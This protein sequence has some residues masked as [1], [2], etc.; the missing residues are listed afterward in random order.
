MMGLFDNQDNDWDALEEQIN[1]IIDIVEKLRSEN[2]ALSGKVKTLEE[3]KKA[4]HQIKQEME[5]K[6]KMLIEKLSSIKE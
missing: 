1:E 4:F 5:K 2:M 6:I 3:E